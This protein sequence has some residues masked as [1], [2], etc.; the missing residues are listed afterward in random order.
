[1]VVTESK[2]FASA[3]SIGVTVFAVFQSVVKEEKKDEKVKPQLD[4]V[5]SRVFALYCTVLKC[6]NHPHILEKVFC[7]WS[8]SEI[9]PALL[10][11]IVE[12]DNTNTQ[13]APLGRLRVSPILNEGT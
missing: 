3:I 6:H 1:M 2:V 10:Y 4:R 13:F 5:S 11:V 7:E 12:Y 9:R 8:N